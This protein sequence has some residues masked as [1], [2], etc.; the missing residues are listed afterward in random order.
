[1]QLNTL[2]ML[3]VGACSVDDNTELDVQEFDSAELSVEGSNELGEVDAFASEPKAA[4]AACTVTNT[5]G[6]V[7]YAYTAPDVSAFAWGYLW[8]DEGRGCWSN[9]PNSVVVGKDYNMCGGHGILYNIIDFWG[10]PAYLPV[11]C[12]SVSWSP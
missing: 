5:S 6:D 7:L 12:T 2:I 10:M 3:V 1:M 8:P 4:R 11:N 9:N